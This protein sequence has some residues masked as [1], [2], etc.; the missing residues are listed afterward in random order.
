MAET[1]NLAPMFALLDRLPAP[2]RASMVSMYHDALVEQLQLLEQALQAGDV[3]EQTRIAHK[4]AGSAAMMQ[5]ASLSLSARAMEAALQQGCVAIAHQ[6]WPRI[7]HSAQQTL[8]GLRSADGA[9]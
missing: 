6:Q 8:Q 3:A 4:L 1:P 5:D 2:V 7:Q 9:A